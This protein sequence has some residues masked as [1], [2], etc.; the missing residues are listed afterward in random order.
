[1][2]LML[3]TQYRENYGAHTWDGTGECPQ[4]WKNKGGIDY[5]VKLGDVTDM[6]AIYELV[7]EAYTKLY[8]SN[9]YV[10]EYVIDWSVESDDYITPFEQDQL[11]YEGV[12]RYG[13]REV[14]W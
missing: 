5:F 11:D 4:Y 2:K 3:I 13:A 6:A 12:I 7:R 1:M 9:D 8:R 10:E 14:K